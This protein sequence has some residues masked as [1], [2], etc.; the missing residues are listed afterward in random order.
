MRLENQGG[1]WCARY[2]TRR[3][4]EAHYARAA[5]PSPRVHFRQVDMFRY[6]MKDTLHAVTVIAV[7]HSRN[8]AQ[9]SQAGA[10]D[11]PASQRGFSACTGSA[12]IFICPTG[13]TQLCLA[14]VGPL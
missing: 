4:L 7:R 6:P 14:V 11:F 2:T 9:G 12:I 13:G 3:G 10:L 1:R 5:V 8:M